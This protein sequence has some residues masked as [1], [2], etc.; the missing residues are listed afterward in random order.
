MEPDA[1]IENGAT[2]VQQLDYPLEV[3]LIEARSDTEFLLKFI[4]AQH[5]LEDIQLHWL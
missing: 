2:P 5:E 1:I 4:D 3:K